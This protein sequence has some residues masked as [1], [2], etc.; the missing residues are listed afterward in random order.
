MYATYWLRSDSPFGLNYK[1]PER[2]TLARD[3][4]SQDLLTMPIIKFSFGS[5]NT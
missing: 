4:Y 1:P 2:F 3:K 5:R